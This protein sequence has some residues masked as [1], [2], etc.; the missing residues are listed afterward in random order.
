MFQD[1]RVNPDKNWPFLYSLRDGQWY[2]TAQRPTQE[3]TPVPRPTPGEM[4]EEVGNARW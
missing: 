2:S 4:E 1:T 3:P